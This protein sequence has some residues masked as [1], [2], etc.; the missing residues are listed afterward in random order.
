M[1]IQHLLGLYTDPAAVADGVDA[2]RAAGFTDANF[3]ILSGTPYPEGAFGEG[4]TPHR[5]FVFPFVGAACGFAVAIL[6][7]VGTQ[8][9]Y[10]L[11]TGGKPILSIPPMVI[12]TY[13]GTMLGAILMTVVGILFESRV[14]RVPLGLYDRRISEGHLGLLV[15]ADETTIARATEALRTTGA[16]EVVQPGPGEG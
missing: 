4:H 13:E 5:L 6:L 2:L 10:P 9:S 3:D 8:I 7:T 15:S 12:V 14:P 11:V 1:A 16:E